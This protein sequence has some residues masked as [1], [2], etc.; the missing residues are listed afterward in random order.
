MAQTEIGALKIAAQKSGVSLQEYQLRI[1]SGEKWCYA[2][3]AWHVVSEFFIDRSRYDGLSALCK[4]A[5]SEK[6]RVKQPQL[7]LRVNG[8]RMVEARDQDRKQARR[9]V[10]F[11]VESRLIPSPNSLPCVDCGHIWKDGERRHEY[12]HYLGYAP[13]NH[14]KVQAVCS[15]CHSKRERGRKSSCQI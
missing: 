15:S 1:T 6:D 4:K 11:L 7:R 8:R 13:E 2:C 14:E 10:N 3:K 9:R 12:D 5:R